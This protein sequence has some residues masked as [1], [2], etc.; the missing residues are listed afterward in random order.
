MT[1]SVGCCLDFWEQDSKE[2]KKPAETE[3]VNW[4]S[5]VIESGRAEDIVRRQ[6]NQE[7]LNGADSL[8]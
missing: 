3:K 8:G 1:S 5:R 7:K 4:A 6:L 2:K